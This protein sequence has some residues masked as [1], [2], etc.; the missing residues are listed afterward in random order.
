M[1]ILVDLDDVLADFDGGFYAEWKRK[2]PDKYIVP[3]DKRTKFY[4]KEEMP[5]EYGSLITEIIISKGFIKSLPEIPN[6]KEAIYR[7]RELKHEV[8]ICTSPFRN[9]KYCVSE[10]YE[11]VEEHL[12]KEWIERLILTSDK[13]LISG[14]YLIDDKPEITGC[15][16]PNWEHILFDR[17]Y[18]RYITNKKRLTWD[19]WDKVI[20]VT[21]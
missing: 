13:T 21:G 15:A 9:Y 16:K 8:F 12:G 18:N 4:L 3:P 11:W 20:N 2:Y 17:S 7:M 5:S 6:A 14:N 10:K 19:N 1:I